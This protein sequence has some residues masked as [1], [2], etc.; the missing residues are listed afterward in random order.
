MIIDLKQLFTGRAEELEIDC[1]LDFSDFEYQNN[2][3]F[4]SLYGCAA[5]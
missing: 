4:W 2:R 1:A 3:P 5:K